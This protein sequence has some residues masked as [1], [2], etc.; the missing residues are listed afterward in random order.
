VLFFKTP[1]LFEFLYPEAVWHGKRDKKR[2]YL[3]F[4]DGPVPIVTEYIL[5]LLA[6]HKIKATFFCVGENVVKNPE[7]FVRIIKEGHDVGNHTHN[8][9][10]GWRVKEQEYINNI[11]LCEEAFQQLG[12]NSNI[13]LFRPPYG[14]IRKK[15]LKKIG[16]D[17]KT[18]M[19]DVLSYDFS[20]KVSIQKCLSKSSKYTKNG[21]IIIF[22]DSI[23]SFD[24]IK[25]VISQYI[26]Y[27]KEKNYEFHIIS[28]IFS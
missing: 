20:Y 2:I 25:L 27:M 9:L 13:P 1:K 26:K 15:T 10:N 19:W 12:Y 14:K 6:E 28:D 23:K 3:T 16:E 11:K 5:D 8:H 17:Y 4:D 21:S 24:K 18:I 7:I 22:H